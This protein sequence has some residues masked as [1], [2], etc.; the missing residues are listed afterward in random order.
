MA[1]S[2][3]KLCSVGCKWM[4]TFNCL[5]AKKFIPVQTN[6]FDTTE[7]GQC[8]GRCFNALAAPSS[9]PFDTPNEAPWNRAAEPPR[10]RISILNG[11]ASAITLLM[12]VWYRNR[13]RLCEAWVVVVCET[14][15]A[16]V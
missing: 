3:E 11:V 14:D 6:S 7:N 8:R 10:M 2:E 5:E 13:I 15:L 1:L 9:R 12:V 4:Y 16:E